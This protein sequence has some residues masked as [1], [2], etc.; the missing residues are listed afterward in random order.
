MLNTAPKI[1]IDVILGGLGRVSERP[2]TRL[3]K[4]DPTPEYLCPR[5][6]VDSA[7]ATNRI[8]TPRT[9]SDKRAARLHTI[10]NVK[11]EKLRQ[12]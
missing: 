4:R 6:L 8:K 9:E 11:S 3:Q 5:S 1:T 12:E 7:I 2:L 10:G